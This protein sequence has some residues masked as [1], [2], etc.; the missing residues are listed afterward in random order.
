MIE[1]TVLPDSIDRIKLI[2]YDRIADK[3]PFSPVLHEFGYA[4]FG[5]SHSVD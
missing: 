5:R 4:K 2:E 1:L 3:H